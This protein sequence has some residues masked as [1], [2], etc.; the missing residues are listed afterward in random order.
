MRS[1]TI[2]IQVE[3]FL[4]IVLEDEPDKGQ[5]LYFSAQLNQHLKKDT[6]AAEKDYELFLQHEK[7]KVFP[8]LAADATAQLQ[9]LRLMKLPR[10]A[11]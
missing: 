4:S 9:K 11:S 6:L 2:A 8:E 10:Q 1:P 5:L 7:A 3:E